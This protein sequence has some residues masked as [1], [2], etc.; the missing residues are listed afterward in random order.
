MHIFRHIKLYTAVL[1]YFVIVC[2]FHKIGR[3]IVTG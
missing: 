3:A 2:E 1:G